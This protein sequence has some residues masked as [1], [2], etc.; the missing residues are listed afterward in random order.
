LAKSYKIQEKKEERFMPIINS[1]LQKRK[2][3]ESQHGFIMVITAYVL[4]FIMLILGSDIFYNINSEAAGVTKDTEE[5]AEQMIYS[6]TPEFTSVVLAETIQ[7][8]NMVKPFGMDE[9]M[10]GL[11]RPLEQDYSSITVTSNN[12][13]EAAN[14]DVEAKTAENDHSPTGNDTVWLLGSPLSG[15]EYDAMFEQMNAIQSL[16]ISKKEKNIPEK[17]SKS[18]GMV[19]NSSGLVSA[20]K[21]RKSSA[22]EANKKK[23]PSI[24]ETGSAYVLDVTAKE[25]EMLERIVE[26]E[27]GGEDMKGKILIANVIFNRMGDKHFPDTVKG[28]IFQ[29]DDGEYQ[30]SPVSDERYWTVKVSK[31]SKEAVKRALEGED[32]S[33][34]A[35]YFIARKKSRSSSARWF[36][37]HLNWLFKHGG[38]EFYKNK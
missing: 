25:V 20:E 29:E 22:K 33:E 4:S 11:Q 6:G 2:M 37:N 21:E 18:S 17:D 8:S 27:A 19:N 23:S 30:F 10:N 24:K 31:S 1:F 3:H 38:H 35:L 14:E 28:V 12:K 15:E 9:I 32:Y 5:E 26:A 13:D 34:G 36:D 7:F 16:S